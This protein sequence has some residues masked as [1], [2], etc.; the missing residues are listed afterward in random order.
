MTD[1]AIPGRHT[2]AL[3]N[4]MNKK[5]ASVLVQLRTGHLRLNSFLYKINTADTDQCECGRGPETIRHYLLLCPRYESQ[6]RTLADKL[7]PQYGNVSHMV[8]G[9]DMHAPTGRQHRDG[10]VE[11]WKPDISVVRETIRFVL[12]SGRLDYGIERRTEAAEEE[13][14]ETSNGEESDETDEEEEEE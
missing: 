14:S 10:P 3:Y 8:G 13:E 9:R 5:E 7:G 6:R 1:S 11:R 2:L 4:T 12:D